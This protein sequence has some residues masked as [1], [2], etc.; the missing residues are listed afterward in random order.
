MSE[1]AAQPSAPKGDGTDPAAASAEY[2]DAEKRLKV[3]EQ[4]YLALAQNIPIGLY[5]RTCG[6]SGIL[7]MA[8]RAMIEIFGYKSADEI[9][10]R[11]VTD[12]YW[13]PSESLAF[14]DSVLKDGEVARRE[15]KLRRKDGSSLWAAVTTKLI[16]DEEGAPAF[17]DGIV[18]DITDRKTAR[19]QDE[20]R[21]KELMH[22]DKMITLGILVS[23]VAHEIN[24]PNQFIM[25]HISPLKEAWEDALP[26]LDRYL[27][28]HGEFML[29]GRK[30]S[31]RRAEISDMFAGVV[32][33]SNRI[34]NIVDEL[35]DYARDHPLNLAGKVDLNT[36]VKSALA[37][38]DNLV[39]KSTRHFTAEYG[40]GLP[41][42]RGDYHRIE[43]VLINLI[44][45]ACQALPDSSRKITVRTLLVQPGNSVAIE[46][47][48]EGV[49]ISPED[50]KHVTDPFFTT[51]RS[52]GGTGLGL[53]ISASIVEKH[54]G[55][56]EFESVQGKGTTVRVVL[57]GA[58]N[59][60]REGDVEP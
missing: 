4:R 43:Q 5:R 42:A 13:D 7:V 32:R 1:V 46:V 41:A 9:V 39:K 8:N 10:G 18:E 21:Q 12:L 55:K 52:Q 48:D 17:F 45:N 3:S 29:G 44:Q 51:K 24:N 16:C 40:A 6:P 60:A 38:L 53:S 56:L 15:L 54:G 25:S 59:T 57:P 28:D 27:R 35:R 19:E 33:G 37:L 34:R 50:L 31:E 23:G 22:I 14:S 47:I 36:V 2:R 58:D 49:G 30:Y 20:L 26:I 11:P